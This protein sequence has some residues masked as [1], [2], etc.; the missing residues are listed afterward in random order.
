MR[1]LLE[2]HQKLIHEL[3]DRNRLG[4]AESEF[5]LFLDKRQKVVEPINAWLKIKEAKH[6][7]KKARGV[8]Q[9]LGEWRE[10]TARRSDI[11]PRYVLSDLALIGIAQRMPKQASDLSNIRGLDTKQFQGDKALS[12]L[13]IVADGLDRNVQKPT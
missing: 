6:L 9:A 13:Q 12:L 4:W 1:Y 7:N 3:D 8:A 10:S 5:Q 2:I 11:P